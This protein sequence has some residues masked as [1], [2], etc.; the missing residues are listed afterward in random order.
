MIRRKLS[1]RIRSTAINDPVPGARRHYSPDA[2]QE[3]NEE[4]FLDAVGSIAR[5][6]SPCW[7]LLIITDPSTPLEIE[8]WADAFG[9]HRIKVLKCPEAGFA[10]ALNHGLH[11]CATQFVSILLSDDRYTSRA[12]AALMA[13]REK[14]PAADFFHSARRHI[15]ES[16]KRWGGVLRSRGEFQLQDFATRGSPV[17]HLLCWRREKI[18]KSAEWMNRCRYMA[19][20]TTTSLGAWP[21]P[22]RGSRRSAPVCM[23]IVCTILMTG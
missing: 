18:S 19:A 11:S 17:K 5:Q 9:D 1:N 3:S 8:Q 20:T 10:R 6:T 16:G 22:E 14:Y 21:K 23:N 7:R 12:I 13:Y 15:T 4:F 2:M